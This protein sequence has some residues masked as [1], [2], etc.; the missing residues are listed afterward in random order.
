MRPAGVSVATS[1]G[2]TL[3]PGLVMTASGT[4]GHSDELASYG[5]LAELGAVVVKSLSCEPW[6]GNPAPR[7]KPLEDGMLNS[8]GLQGPGLEAW[9]SDDLP[10]LRARGAVVVVSIWGR[11]VAE[12]ARAGEMLAAADVDAI[13]VNISCPNLEARSE[14]FAHSPEAA[15]AAIEA[16]GGAHPRWA[17][18]SPNTSKLVEVAERAAAA[19]ADALTLTNTVLGMVIDVESRRLALGAG[20]GGVSGR[21]IHP[22]AVR[23]VYE[24]RS[25]LPEMPLIG[26]GGIMT[27][28]DAIEMFMAGACAVQVGTAALA[29]PRAPWRVQR[30]IRSWM[31]AHGVREIDEIKGAAHG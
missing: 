23:A 10:R 8:V 29:E 3:L 7:L 14:M 16:V 20:G 30:E 18:L 6:P 25:A 17:K 1:V 26:V 22:V 2:A 21:A 4:A 13:E 28:V 15:F 24:C 9:I 19:G 5:D 12:Y 31:A 27:G 11:S